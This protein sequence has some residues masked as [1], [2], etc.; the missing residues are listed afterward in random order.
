VS[1]HPLLV[2]DERFHTAVEELDSDAMRDLWCHHPPVF[3]LHP[4]GVALTT[5]DAVTDSWQQIFAGLSYAEVRRGHF[6]VASD[7]GSWLLTGTEHVTVVGSAG[8]AGELLLAV[9]VYRR[10]QAEWRL[11]VHVAQPFRPPNS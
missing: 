9:R 2:L 11:A 4:G 3:C 7:G 5:P 1:A 10:E 6:T 8:R